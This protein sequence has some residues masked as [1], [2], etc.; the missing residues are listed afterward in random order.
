MPRLGSRSLPLQA[1][2]VVLALLVLLASGVRSGLFDDPSARPATTGAVQTVQTSPPP[3]GQPT[4][5]DPLDWPGSLVDITLKLLAV[6]ALAYVALA[7]L[8]RYT[9]GAHAR[10]GGGSLQVLESAS[11]APNREIY[12]V[13]AGDKRLL[14]GVTPTRIETLATWEDGPPPGPP[15]ERRETGDTAEMQLSD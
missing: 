3:A 15:A 7:A 4:G 10:R 1:I 11:L 6:L 13:R 14:L 2:V 12:L 9:Y 8:R 5:S